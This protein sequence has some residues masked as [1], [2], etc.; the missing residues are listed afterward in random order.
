LQLIAKS[1]FWGRKDRGKQCG[2]PKNGRSN[3]HPGFVK[4]WFSVNILTI[5]L[6][7]RPKPLSDMGFVGI[8]RG[9]T[10]AS[11]DPAADPICR[12]TAE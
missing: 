10:E 5:I 7:A 3:F 9:L 12:L 6:R 1:S 2:L 4:H 11:C 8:S